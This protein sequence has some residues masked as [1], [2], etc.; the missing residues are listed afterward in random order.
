MTTNSIKAFLLLGLL[1]ALI[2]W[3]GNLVG[4]PVGLVIAL[5]LAVGMNGYSYWYSDKMEI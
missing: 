3:I 4:G 1:T 5:V 2:L